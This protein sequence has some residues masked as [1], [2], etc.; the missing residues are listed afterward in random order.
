MQGQ[1]RRLLDA[2]DLPG[3]SLGIIPARAR[4]LV[5]PGGGFSIFDSSR[6]EVQ[7]Y[8]RAETITDQDLVALFSKAFGLLKASAVYGQAARELI[9]SALTVSCRSWTYAGGPSLERHLDGSARSGGA[10]PSLSGAGTDPSRG[11]SPCSKRAVRAVRWAACTR[12]RHA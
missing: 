6:V 1:L 5:H 7:G 10:V 11:L 3:L 8:G 4:L 9:T 2:T 12:D